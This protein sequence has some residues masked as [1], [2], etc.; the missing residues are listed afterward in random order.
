MSTQEKKKTTNK[1]TV[2]GKE[3]EVAE[4]MC[5][6][7]SL[8]DMKDVMPDMHKITSATSTIIEILHHNPEME[9]N[10][11]KRSAIFYSVLLRLAHE[12]LLSNADKVGLFELVKM[13]LAKNVFVAEQIAQTED[14]EDPPYIS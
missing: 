6:W 2:C 4:N 11:T 9:K 14:E 8:E 13:H 5:S 10:C 7:S 12:V 1:C 3:V